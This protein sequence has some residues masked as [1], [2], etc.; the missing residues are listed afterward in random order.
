[1]LIGDKYRILSDSLNITLYEK[2]KSKKPGATTW[3]AIAFF[4]NPKDALKHLINLKVM[5]TEL[6]DLETV[7]KR[8]DELYRLVETL[9]HL[10][11]RVESCRRSTK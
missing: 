10:P 1:M 5:E 4:S 11:E 3:R 8:I 9:K 7:C 6:K 2:A